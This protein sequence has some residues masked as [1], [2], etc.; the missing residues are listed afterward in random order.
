M[1]GTEQIWW[2]SGVQLR[3]SPQHKATR[4]T[5]LSMRRKGKEKG[6]RQR[7]KGRE[8][9]KRR[10]TFLRGG[11]KQLKTILLLIKTKP[12]L[13]NIDLPYLYQ[14]ALWNTITF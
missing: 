14:V 7:E 11:K 5:G 10:W 8:K 9:W 12:K 2:V 1:G 4:I 13:I 3:V 6:K